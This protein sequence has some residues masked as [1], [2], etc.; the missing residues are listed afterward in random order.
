MS[1]DLQE[2]LD[3]LGNLTPEEFKVLEEKVKSGYRPEPEPSPANGSPN[4]TANEIKRIF[5]PGTYHPTD[6]EIEAEIA[7]ILTPEERAELDSFD[8]RSIKIPP[9]AKS[10][11]ELISEDREDRF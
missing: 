1:T 10:S 6:E 5:I 9:G 11:A 2:I 8:P 7:A 3:R 4:G